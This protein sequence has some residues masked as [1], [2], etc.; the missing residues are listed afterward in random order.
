MVPIKKKHTI[1]FTHTHTHMYRKPPNFSG[2]YRCF[3][4]KNMSMCNRLMVLMPPA[5]KF[6]KHIKPLLVAEYC[7]TKIP[8]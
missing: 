2:L 4:Y 8:Y 3:D 1:K 6:Y 7:H 5:V